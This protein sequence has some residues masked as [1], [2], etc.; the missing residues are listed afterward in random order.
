M[1]GSD[2]E[3]VIHIASGQQI[4]FTVKGIRQNINACYYPKLV[5]GHEKAQLASVV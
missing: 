2:C 3:S 1:Q 4:V 5:V